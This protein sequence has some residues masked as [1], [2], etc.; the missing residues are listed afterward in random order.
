MEVDQSLV[1][2]LLTVIGYS[3]NDTVIVFDRVRD[4]VKGRTEG[5]FEDVVNHS[6][7]TTLSRTF[8]T[9]ATI[10]VVL[11]IMFIFCGESIR[12]FV[13]AMLLGI[14]VGTYSSLF[15]STPILVD[16]AK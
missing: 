9:S 12:G 8:N 14:G 4:F 15:I 2:A 16:T 11:L 10:I 7:N 6:I 13:F 3:L 1:A 5:S